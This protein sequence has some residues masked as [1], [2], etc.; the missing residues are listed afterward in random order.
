M[1]PFSF[2]DRSVFREMAD[3]CKFAADR[4]PHRDKGTAE[5]IRVGGF[6][7]CGMD[8]RDGSICCK[9]RVFLS[10]ERGR[11]VSDSDYGTC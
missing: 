7:Q 6:S 11:C 1:C 4:I 5:Y 9:H 3:E 8:E 2:F 10:L